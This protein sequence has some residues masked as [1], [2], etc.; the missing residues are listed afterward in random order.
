MAFSPKGTGFALIFHEETNPAP[1][2][3]K[4]E[5]LKLAKKKRVDVNTR[6]LKKEI[7]AAIRKA[8]KKPPTKLKKPKTP[9][10]KTTPAKQSPTRQKTKA[11]KP[12]SPENSQPA[13]SATHLRPTEE[14]E[15][16]SQEAKFIVAPSWVHQEFDPLP[17]TA[18]PQGY[19]DHKLVMMVRDP[20]WAYLYWE[21]NPEAVSHALN[22]ASCGIHQVRC[23]LRVHPMSQ[24]DAREFDVDID[25]RTGSHYLNL[26][27]P[28][29]A[30][31]SEIGFITPDGR[32]VSLA[33]S[34]SIALPLDRPSDELDERWLTTDAEFQQI[35]ELSGGSPVGQRP[36]EAGSFPSGFSSFASSGLSS[37]VGTSPYGR[38]VALEL[39]TDL[40]LYGNTQAGNRV[41]IAG[42]RIQVQSDGSFTTKARLPEGELTLPITVES[43]EGEVLERLTPVITKK[44]RRHQKEN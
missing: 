24:K 21:L 16:P 10:K 2:M 5:L 14:L 40:V 36:G 32:F 42:E 33:K 25:F 22:K 29:H 31:Y 20:W 8:D 7:I 23:V 1:P 18:L 27:A 15:D 37:P 38:P 26:A 41:T 28:G 35:Y 39:K 44:I 12:D 6:M 3:T 4:I 13:I 30:F 9:R 34:N 19:G 17:S 43:A 11:T